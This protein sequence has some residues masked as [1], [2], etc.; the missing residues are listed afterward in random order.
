MSRT[1]AS[2]LRLGRAITQGTTFSFANPPCLPHRTRALSS[3][4]CLSSRGPKPTPT[5]PPPAPAGPGVE[6][7][8]RPAEGKPFPPAW[9]R[10]TLIAA[11]V[12]GTL[13]G[14]Y[15]WGQS[16]SG[17]LPLAQYLLTGRELNDTTFVPF[18]IVSR[19]PVTADT[20][21][22]TLRP[23]HR[24]LG[25][26][27][28]AASRFH[29][30]RLDWLSDWS[31]WIWL[32]GA[33]EHSNEAVYARAWAHG[34]WAVE[35][36][37]PQLQIVREYTPLPPPPPVEGGEEEED[38]W[39]VSRRSGDLRILVR[40]VDGGE[41]S[42]YLA[43]LRLG[44]VVELRGPH[45]G[46]DV[47]RRLG[48]GGGTEREKERRVVFLAGGTGI[49]PALQVAH[50][51]LDGDDDNDANSKPSVSILWANR[52]RR[53]LAPS[54][55]VVRQLDGMARR[56]GGRLALQT[57]VDEDK[58]FIDGKLVAAAV[59]PAKSTAAAAAASAPAAPPDGACPYHSEALLQRTATDPPA[60]E[61]GA[62]RCGPGASAGAGKDLVF[63]SGPD[64]FVNKFAG[65]KVWRDKLEL[66]GPVGGLLGELKKKN[67]ERLRNWLVLKL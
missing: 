47:K 62:C 63:V 25:A 6:S 44:A 23:R 59:L 35:V 64:G 22:L 38:P 18:T 21:V 60:N 5:A 28:S 31:P 40:A 43:R 3:T 51:L 66:Q 53:S 24:T 32:T 41:V 15:A 8:P 4:P 45:L 33:R 37:Q 26:R 14:F 65:A 61:G 12:G 58:T 57:F 9:L 34:L 11:A 56:H 2:K 19:E 55:P 1:M 17:D 39:E 7:P 16:R 54:S 50:A 46:L 49:S 20:S 52:E 27:S 48:S 36:K 67:A 30:R 13:W 10:N 42:S 29:A